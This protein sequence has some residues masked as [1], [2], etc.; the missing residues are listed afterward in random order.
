MVRETW[1]VCLLILVAAQAG[2]SS[3]AYW[4][5]RKRDAADIFTFTV[6]KGFGAKVRAGIVDV[7][8]FYNSDYKGLRGGA[9]F[10]YEE[11][12]GW[13]GPFHVGP[14][15]DRVTPVPL[16]VNSELPPW[17]LASSVEEFTLPHQTDYYSVEPEPIWASERR[18]KDFEA[19]M[20]YI[21]FLS[22]SNKA[23]YYTQLEVAAGAGYTVRL[24][25]NPGELLDFLLGWTT[26]DILGDD[27]G[28][29]PTKEELVATLA[30]AEALQEAVKRDD[31]DWVRS[32]LDKDPALANAQCSDGVPVLYRAASK[33]D[34]DTVKLLLE[35]G[36][37]VSARARDGWTPIFGA[38]RSG[39]VPTVEALIAAGADVNARNDVGDTPLHYAA[40]WGQSDT[41]AFLCAHGA[42]TDA[43]EQYGRTPAQVAQ[44]RGFYDLA[45]TLRST[46]AKSGADQ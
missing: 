34:V 7:G 37:D 11:N 12:A 20:P 33:G 22:L 27:V 35:R 2:C 43:K 16:P 8:L 42:R 45:R 25:F 31:L 30:P 15:M 29:P 18:G 40:E 36:A 23:Y 21:P 14:N 28:L 38:A 41:A 10:R 9:S 17:L 13:Q 3:P 19:G 32:L 44:D 1:I 4:A 46:A 6:G 39:S 24:G 5:D 26:L